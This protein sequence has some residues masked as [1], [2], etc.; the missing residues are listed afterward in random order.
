MSRT[1]WVASLRLRLLLVI[2]LAV[3]LA[4]AVAGVLLSQIFRAHVMQQQ[5]AA[6]TQQLDQLTARLEV[7]AQGLAR[8]DSR[9]LS[10]PRWQKPYSGLYWQLD[11][12]SPAGASQL[13]VLRSRSLWD[14]SLQ[15]RSDALAPGA[16]HRHEGLGPMQTPLMI[17]ERKVQ[18]AEGPEAGWRII[19]AT[20]L[21]A[22]AEAAQSFNKVLA[23]SLMVLFVLLALA[24]WAQVAVGLAPLRAL[25]QAVLDVHHGRAVQL[26]GV[27]PTEVQALVEDFNAVLT[28]HA[29][30]LA[31]ARLHAGNLAHA[32]KTPLTVLEQAASQAPQQSEADFLRV[33]QEQVAVARRHINWHLARARMAASLRLPGQRTAVSPV[34]NGLVRVL[35]RVYAE[36]NIDIRIALS[37]PAA[38]FA[39]EEQDLQEMLGNL[40]DNAC[41]WTRTEVSINVA[42]AGPS[43]ASAQIA[44]QIDDD[45]PGIDAAHRAL[46]FSRGVRLDESVPGS[47]LGLAIVRDLSG[48]YGGSLELATSA[49]GG[50]RATLCLPASSEPTMAAAS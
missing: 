38:C 7:D 24:A 19:V 49:A 36:K 14:I 47:G 15:L 9:A 1:P 25:Q 27:F 12:V 37:D 29:A 16:V 39:G 46:V 23:S 2:S 4:L 6:L 5:E 41:K 45:G 11:R 50:L 21:T 3:A 48:L 18:L 32:L 34:L 31:R 26:A 33:V 43:Q 13:A 42:H 10:D 20:D 35:Q 22:T 30:V 40:L 17:L 28:Q 8:I 44:I